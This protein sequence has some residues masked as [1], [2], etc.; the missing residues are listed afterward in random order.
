MHS[1]RVYACGLHVHT[2][3]EPLRILSSKYKSGE[4]SGENDDP[5]IPAQKLGCH[6]IRGKL[7]WLLAL[8]RASHYCQARDRATLVT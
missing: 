6:V 5:T 8:A 3:P 7:T 2:H 4:N 1:K